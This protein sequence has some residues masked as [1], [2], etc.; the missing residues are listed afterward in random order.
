M[1]RHDGDNVTKAATETEQKNKLPR[2]RQMSRK[3][4]KNEKSKDPGSKDN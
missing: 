3:L 2:D 1:E 4:P